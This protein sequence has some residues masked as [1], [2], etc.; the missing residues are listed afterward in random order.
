MT[1]TLAHLSDVHLGPLPDF[2]P[3][4]WGVKRGLGYLNWHRNR[5]HVHLP[6]V[7][8]ALVSDLKAQPIDHVAVTGD[9]VN[10]GLP[11]EY[12][13]ALDWLRNLGTPDRVTVVPGNH[14]IYVRLRG[15]PGIARWAAYMTEAAH[16]QLLPAVPTFPFVR[17]RGGVALIGL[18]SAV[19]TRPLIASGTLGLAQRTAVADL[20]DRLGR[21]NVVRIVLIH[22]P[23]LEGLT[24]ANRALRD[25]APLTDLLSHH[26][27]ELVIYG[28]NHRN[29]CR[30]IRRAAG[31]SGI[32]V[33]GI[34]SASAG[35][36][37]RGEPMARYNMFRISADGGL[38][39][40]EV[41]ARGLSAPGEPIVELDRWH[42][43]PS[44]A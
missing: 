34:A 40:I 43:D 28:H 35:S 2:R 18:N 41:V 37:S 38:P 3:R 7:L 25:A 10:L 42:L 9:L 4:H 13:R 29:D 39:A 16:G 5:K 21:E 24:S 8:A 44:R 26:G 20:L 17:R 22:H 30:W 36:L 33:V 6:D 15:D 23:P 1:F 12:E 31:Q 14:D 11:A 32:P 19:P 27:A